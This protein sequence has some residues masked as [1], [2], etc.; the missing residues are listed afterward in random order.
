MSMQFVD[1]CLSEDAIYAIE[2]MVNN[3]ISG[4]YQNVR[5]VILGYNSKNDVWESKYGEFI[6]HRY[7]RDVVHPESSPT[8]VIKNIQPIKN[9]KSNIFVNN[10]GMTFYDTDVYEY[11]RVYIDDSIKR[12]LEVLFTVSEN[13][14]EYKDI[15]DIIVTEWNVNNVRDTISLNRS[16]T[17][18]GV[19]GDLHYY[20]LE[21]RKN[22]W[23]DL[24]KI[25]RHRGLTIRD[26][27]KDAVI[28]FLESR[29]EILKYTIGDIQY[30][31]Y[32]NIS[33]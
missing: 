16:Y 12:V 14:I 9:E 29:S 2:T 15:I 10:N 31:I 4:N 25:T 20:K 32:Q 26:A 3:H 19:C 18:H 28:I 27:F 5:D 11:I 24:K 1:K 7:I 33:D 8:Y 22:L 13:V 23:E 17:D 6:A 21:V 30:G